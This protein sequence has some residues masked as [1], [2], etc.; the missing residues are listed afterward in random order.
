MTEGVVVL[1]ET[2]EVKLLETD[3]SN[4]VAVGESGVEKEV[5]EDAQSSKMVLSR[6][7]SEEWSKSVD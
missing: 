3:N 7:S 5:G 1:T 2:G 6:S 4:W